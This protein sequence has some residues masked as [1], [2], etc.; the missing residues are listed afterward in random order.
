MIMQVIESYARMSMSL[1]DGFELW[2]LLVRTLL[3][4]TV[5]YK[6]KSRLIKNKTD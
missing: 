4:I 5:V 2:V 6:V 1:P 3:L